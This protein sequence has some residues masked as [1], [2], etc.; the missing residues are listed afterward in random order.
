MIFSIF[1]LFF[2]F[3]M[4]II[5]LLLLLRVLQHTLLTLLEHIVFFLRLRVRLLPILY[6]IVL[7]FFL[8]NK[9]N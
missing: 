5:Y 9:I 3:F 8:Y 4:V 1:F 2:L 6:Y 7:L